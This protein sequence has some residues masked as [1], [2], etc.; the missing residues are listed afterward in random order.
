MGVHDKDGERQLSEPPATREELISLLVAVLAKGPGNPLGIVSLRIHAEGCPKHQI[1]IKNDLE[2][3]STMKSTWQCSKDTFFVAMQSLVA[4]KLQI[5]CLNLFRNTDMKLFALASDQFNLIDWDRPETAHVLATVTPLNMN[6]STRVFAFRDRNWTA[7]Q[8]RAEAENEDFAYQALGIPLPGLPELKGF[9]FPNWKILQYVSKLPSLPKLYRLTLRFQFTKESA[10][11][12]LLKRTR[13]AGLFIGPMWLYPGK[14]KPIFEFC[15]SP[16]S[17]MQKFGV[18]GPTYQMD[19]EERGQVQFQRQPYNEDADC[20][21][22]LRRE[23]KVVRRPIHFDLD[24]QGR[25]DLLRLAHHF[26]I[27]LLANSQLKSSQAHT[28]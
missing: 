6:I 27:L 21:A 7:R 8:I 15:S 19:L 25:R 16:E 23:G 12:N 26:T 14:L 18:R 22:H 9:Q 20:C 17:K 28:F 13:P 10:V 11:L 4:A 3:R 2:E 24:P 5:Q 1:Q